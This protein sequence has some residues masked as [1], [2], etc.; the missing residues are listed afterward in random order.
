[1]KPVEIEILL[2]DR[3][4]GGLD[5][6]QRKLDS[7]M[8]KTGDTTE[9]VT[10]LRAAIGALTLQLETLEKAGGPDIDQTQNIARAEQLRQKIGELQTQLEQLDD[11][12][13]QTQAVPSGMEKARTAYNGLHMSIQQIAREMPSLAMGPQMFFLAISNNLPVFTDELA[14]ARKEYEALTASGQKAT[15]VWRQV[16]SSLF[17]WQTALTTGIMLLVMYGKAIT[18]WVSSLFS[19]DSAQQRAAKRAKQKKLSAQQHTSA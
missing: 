11:T 19:A 18:E 5:A 14:R 9:R 6:M 12:A 10:V 8:A 15:P 4:S 7:L 17:S 13:R 2:K 3:L 1:M 16:L